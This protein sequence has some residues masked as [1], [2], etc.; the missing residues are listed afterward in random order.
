M[1]TT[2]VEGNPVRTYDD[3]DSPDYNPAA[4]EADRKIGRAATD[5]IRKRSYP[6]F[7]E[8][9]HVGVGGYEPHLIFRNG[10]SFLVVET[11]VRDS[12]E[13]D[14]G[15]WGRQLDDGRVAE[16]GSRPYLLAGIDDLSQR[17]EEGKAIRTAVRSALTANRVRYLLVSV[18]VEGPVGN[19]KATGI[20][21]EEYKL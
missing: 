2:P 17:T 11:E 5:V 9:V 7:V 18:V 19:Q 21:S 4:V 1:P 8:L 15:V 12:S 10:D 13:E 20:E 16:R 6:A 14:L 3:P